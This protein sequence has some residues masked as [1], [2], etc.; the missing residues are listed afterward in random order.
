MD[1][2]F[3]K[4]AL[5]R[6]RDDP[7]V[8]APAYLRRLTVALGKLVSTRRKLY[9]DTRYWIFLRDAAM[10][11][12]RRPEHSELLELLRGAV[13]SG[14]ALCPISDV[15]YLELTKQT[16]P[17]TKLETTR[18]V[19]ELSLGIALLTEESRVGTELA[20][21]MSELGAKLELPPLA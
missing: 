5:A 7:T 4:R 3:V 13:Q 8:S 16:D 9:L 6:H 21:T 12:P 2:E 14:V 1:S 15:G 18:L 11:R 20:H 17:V 19:D 10:G